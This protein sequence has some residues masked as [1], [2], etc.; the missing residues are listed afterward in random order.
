MVKRILVG[1]MKIS[2]MLAFRVC[3]CLWN[4]SLLGEYNIVDMRWMAS[5]LSVA[6]MRNGVFGSRQVMA[7]RMAASSARSGVLEAYWVVEQWDVGCGVGGRV[8][9]ASRDSR[10]VVAA[11]CVD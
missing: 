7:T 2:L 10:F 11:I 6:M 9:E 5:W 1:L 3:L 4:W 8:I